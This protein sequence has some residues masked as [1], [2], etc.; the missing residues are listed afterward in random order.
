MKSRT[1]ILS[2]VF[3]LATLSL[4]AQHPKHTI[5]YKS[6]DPVDMGKYMLSFE[7]MTSRTAYT[8][9]EVQIKNLTDDYLLVK[10]EESTFTINGQACHP[11]QK[12]IIINPNGDTEKKYKVEGETNYHVDNFSLKMDGIYVVPAKGKVHKAP[13]YKLPITEDRISFG[14]FS[15]TLKKL[16]KKTKETY[17]SFEVLYTGDDVGIVDVSKVG[18]VVP[19]KGK[20]EFSN[21]R[22]KNKVKLL[23]KGDKK[24]VTVVF[25]IPASYSDM[26]YANM[27]ILWREA[28][29]SSKATKAKSATVK[30]EIDPGLTDGKN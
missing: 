19:D 30:F 29:Q 1:L 28:F 23:H 5:Y 21:S 27:E 9:V 2:C 13:N 20:G 11:P 16:K 7:K 4:F 15:L 3:V 18:V 26:Q 14:D 17:A 8:R 24:T 6:V 10:K 12:W 22:S 25:N